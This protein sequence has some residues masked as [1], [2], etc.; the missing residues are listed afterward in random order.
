MIIE[1]NDEILI[2]GSVSSDSF[3]ILV[4][5][6]KEVDLQFSLELYDEAN[7]LITVV[8]NT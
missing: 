6:M 2:H 1:G 3:T 4:N 7:E 8:D 5:K